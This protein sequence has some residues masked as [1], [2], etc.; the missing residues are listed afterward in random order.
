MSL[1]DSR[2]E[3]DDFSSL[4]TNASINIVPQKGKGQVRGSALGEPG[5]M[6]DPDVINTINEYEPTEQRVDEREANAFKRWMQCNEFPHEIFVL[7]TLYS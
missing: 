2:E 1:E 4:V 7:I 6:H 3:V 5:M